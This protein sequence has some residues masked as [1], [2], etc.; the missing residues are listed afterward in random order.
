MVAVLEASHVPGMA[1]QKGSDDRADAVYLD[2]AR[3]RCLDCFHDARL[4]V[5]DIGV[6]SADV[7]DGPECEALSLAFCEGRGLHPPQDSSRSVSGEPNGRSTR[8]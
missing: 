8:D 2:D 5:C 7:G 4:R 1:D 3:S 6:E